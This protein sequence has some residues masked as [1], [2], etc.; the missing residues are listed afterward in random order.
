MSSPT[1]QYFEK[2]TEALR[3]IEEKET[4]A[5]TE[6]AEVMSDAIIEDELIHVIGPGGHSNIGAHEMFWRAGGLVPINPILDA[7]T[8][9][10]HGA[11]RSNYIERTPGYAKAVFDAYRVNQGVLII[12]N[13]YG[14]NAMT[15]DCALEA[16]ERG[17][18]SIGVTSTSFAK[19][20]PADHPARHPSGKNLHEIVDIFVNCHM[21]YGDA[22]VKFDDLEQ[23]VAPTST[24]VNCFTVNLLT[25]KTVEVLLD[26]GADVPLWRSANLPGGDEANRQYEEDYVGRVKH[27]M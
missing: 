10:I 5:I 15:I 13:A 24:L 18:T 20:V 19:E 7:G 16:R 27:L 26:K 14:I 25:I 9:L 3:Q 22:V 12:V 2:V 6:A 11:K 23:K 8:A 21:P 1:K 17:L 4:E